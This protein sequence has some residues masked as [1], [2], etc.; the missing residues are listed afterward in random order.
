MTELDLTFKDFLDKFNVFGEGEWLTVYSGK[1]DDDEESLYFYSGLIS[2]AHL[3]ASL[4]DP[5]WDIQIGDGQP[6]FS[7]TFGAGG[8]SEGTYSKSSDDGLE[9]LVIKRNFGGIKDG[10]WEV[11]EEFRLYF[12]LFED[13]KNSKFILIDDDGD[14]EEVVIMD[15]NEIKIKTKLI[16]KYLAVKKMSLALYFDLGRFSN[17]T[18]DQLGLKENH[19]QK[20]GDDYIYSIGVSPWDGYYLNQ[21]RSFGSLRGKKI[22]GGLK[23]YHPSFFEKK[24]KKYIDFVIDIDSDGKEV[25]FTCNDDE[26]SN[27]FGKNVGKPHYLTPVVFNKEVLTK[28]YSQPDKYSVE[29]GYLRC[30]GLWGL[31]MDNNSEEQ[32]MVYLGDLGGLSYK[33]QLHWRSYNL[34]TKGRMSH[35]AWSRDFESEFTDPQKSDLYFKYKLDEF[36][37]EW[38][39]KYGWRLFLPLEKGDEHYLQS[40]HLPLTNGQ[41]EFDEQVLSLVKVIIDSLNEKKLGE[42]LSVGPDT[43][44]IGKFESFLASKGLKFPQMIEFLKSL[45]MLRSGGVAHRKGEKYEK[46]KDYFLIGKKDLSVVFDDI[47]MKSIWTLNTLDRHLLH[48]GASD[49][50]GTNTPQL[51]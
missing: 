40:L 28:Y 51:P 6:G 42:G 37:K 9:P 19:E 11:S 3:K 50:I 26:L 31:R 39:K 30:G 22:I 17:R 25:L 15:E 8:E 21:K 48:N 32:V 1:K 13:K 43:K 5:S 46:I 18:L 2:P 12:N 41:K 38:E 14:E 10:Y 44:G 47:L 24:D 45:Q 34:S 23:D 7:Y 35:V 16:K 20:K 29:D 49:D 27:Y 36:Q 4:E 33:E